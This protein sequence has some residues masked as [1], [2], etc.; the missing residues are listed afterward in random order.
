MV[1]LFKNKYKKELAEYRHILGSEAAAYY[2]LAANNGYTLDLDP[3]GNP[4]KLYEALLVENAGDKE[5]AIMQKLSAYLP[6]FFET[7]GDWVTEGKLEP[8]IIDIQEGQS[9]H[10][11]ESISKILGSTQLKKSL[12][13]LQKEND[14]FTRNSLIYHYIQKTRNS[15]VEEQVAK[16]I[17]R[18]HNPSP[19]DLYGFRLGSQIDWN[20]DKIKEIIGE[21]QEKLAKVFGLTK[22]KRADGTFVYSSK[23]KSKDSRLRVSFVNSITGQ[24]WTDEDGVVH[25]GLFEE[26]SNSEERTLCTM[27]TGQA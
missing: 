25:K 14:L 1:C 7:Y 6:Q 24:D 23:D 22:Q 8:S 19:V 16:Y 3:T 20:E 5:S 12:E 9:T 4:S 11:S 21:Q 10:T 17:S 15:F 18:R 26:N 27:F 2:A 13:T